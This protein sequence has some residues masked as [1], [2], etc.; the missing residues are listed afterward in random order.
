M[1]RS[2][3]AFTKVFLLGFVFVVG[4]GIL[5]GCGDSGDNATGTTVKEDESQK[6]AKID[7]EAKIR[8]NM[9]KGKAG[10]PAK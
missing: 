4:S 1:L 7:M 9:A 10:A 2:L 3:Y 5:S 6:A 8:E